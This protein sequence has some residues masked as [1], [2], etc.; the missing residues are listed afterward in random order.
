MKVYTL[1]SKQNLP[2]SVDEAWEF[3]SAP[4]NLKTITPD[5]MSF[6]ILSGG[7]RPMFPGQII[8]YIVTPILGI[9]TKWVTE[10]THVEDRKYFVDEQ[11]FGPYA[12]WHHKHFIKEIPGGVEMEDI[13]D[14]KLPMGILG[15]FVHPIIV[16]PKLDEIFEY[17]RKKLIEL[18]GEYRTP[19][20]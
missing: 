6:D 20:F 18:F 16:K 10:I 8:Q 1:H 12:L 2:I 19:T 3:L 4:K 5:Y 15:Q 11:R 9:K 13:I 17:R 14:Y 7:D